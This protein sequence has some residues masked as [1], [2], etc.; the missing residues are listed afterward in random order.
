M[1]GG[2]ENHY[3]SR[4]DFGWNWYCLAQDGVAPARI[5][6]ALLEEN[7]NVHRSAL[8]STRLDFERRQLPESVVRA[9]VHYYNSD[10]EIDQLVQAI[11]EAQ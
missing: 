6:A 8:S 1:L 7:I 4:R 9:S 3:S 2:S 5:Q 11:L 10:E